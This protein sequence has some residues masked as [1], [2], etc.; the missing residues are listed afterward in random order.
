MEAYNFSAGASITTVHAEREGNRTSVASAMTMAKSVF[1]IAT[2]ITSGSEE[3]KMDSN[4]E[5]DGA[6]G[7]EIDGM[8][9]VEGRSRVSRTT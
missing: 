5:M 7:V 6:S 4:K 2:N 9:M 8:E 1:S 3:G